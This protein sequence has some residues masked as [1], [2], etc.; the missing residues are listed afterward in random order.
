MNQGVSSP[1]LLN[2]LIGANSMC[3]A[4]CTSLRNDQPC[5]PAGK[6]MVPL[7]VGDD[8]DSEAWCSNRFTISALAINSDTD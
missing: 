1:E 4:K 3:N 5:S 2:E 7:T 8:V 6:C